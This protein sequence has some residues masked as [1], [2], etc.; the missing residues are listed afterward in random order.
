MNYLPRYGLCTARAILEDQSW[1]TKEVGIDPH[2][3]RTNARTNHSWPLEVGENIRL[4]RRG[5]NLEMLIQSL[6]PTIFRSSLAG[7]WCRR[8]LLSL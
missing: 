6:P 8:N 5:S 1:P 7:D 4:P 2:Q 3:R